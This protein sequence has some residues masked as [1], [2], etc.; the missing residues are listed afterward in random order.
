LGDVTSPQ[1]HPGR[2]WDVLR[3]LSRS[4]RRRGLGRVVAGAAC[5]WF[6]FR[7]AG[8]R[9]SRRR[10]RVHW[11]VPAYGAKPADLPVLQ[12]TKF[13]FV[14]NLQ[15]ARALGLEVPSGLLLAADEVIE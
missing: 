15:T 14:I 11:D 8:R 13:E 9:R 10:G 12:L 3:L 1:E 4:D 5:R 7:R 2:L 6:R